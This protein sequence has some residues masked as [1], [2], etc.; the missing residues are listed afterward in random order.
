MAG[1]GHGVGLGGCEVG[2]GVCCRVGDKGGFTRVV[3][4]CNG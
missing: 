1:E 2:T 4:G 3:G